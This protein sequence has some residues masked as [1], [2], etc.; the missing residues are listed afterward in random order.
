MNELRARAARHL[1]IAEGDI[2]HCIR[3]D[4]GQVVVIDREMR[5]YVLLEATLPELPTAEAPKVEP[6]KKARRAGRSGL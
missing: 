6:E 2:T 4:N 1:G 3:R 5:K